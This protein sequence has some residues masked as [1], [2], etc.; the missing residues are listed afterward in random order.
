VAEAIA[1]L[2]VAGEEEGVRNALLAGYNL[3]PIVGN[4]LH[5]PHRGG[6]RNSL[7]ARPGAPNGWELLTWSG[8][9]DRRGLVE[10]AKLLSR[11]QP[12]VDLPLMPDEP[13]DLPALEALGR[14]FQGRLAEW[15]RYAS[16]T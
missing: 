16:R 9:R 8:E 5:P 2:E 10:L 4:R 3:G 12:L 13:T 6:R 7:L 14:Q 1:L 15:E 11:E